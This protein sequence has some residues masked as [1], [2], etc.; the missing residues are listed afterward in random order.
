M[1]ARVNHNDPSNV[2]DAGFQLSLAIVA[3]RRLFFQKAR[4]NA[5]KSY[6]I[7]D[8]AIKNAFGYN[9]GY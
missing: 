6:K 5:I 4:K 8:V 1:T 3:K 2:I 9:F 7:F